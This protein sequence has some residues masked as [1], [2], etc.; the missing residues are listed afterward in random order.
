MWWRPYLIYVFNALKVAALG[1]VAV[2]AWFLALWV[3]G[4]DYGHALLGWYEPRGLSTE[5]LSLFFLFLSIGVL[6]VTP[7]L[8][9]WRRK[10]T[11]TGNDGWPDI[12]GGGI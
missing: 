12:G 7:L 5:F 4:G 10:G 1:A 6:I 2:A 8:W 9:G 11:T 3:R